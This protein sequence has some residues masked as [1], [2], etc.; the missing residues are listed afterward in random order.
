MDHAVASCKS[1]SHWQVCSLERHV[2]SLLIN[3]AILILLDITSETLHY[4]YQVLKVVPE[5]RHEENFVLSLLKTNQMV[6][7]T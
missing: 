1:E 5:E 4:R 7:L 2:A 6:V 3:F